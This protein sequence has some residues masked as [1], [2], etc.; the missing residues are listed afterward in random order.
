MYFRELSVQKINIAKT[1]P[2]GEKRGKESLPIILVIARQVLKINN[3]IFLEILV[4]HIIKKDKL[5]S[6]HTLLH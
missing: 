2:K 3:V 5:T 1:M 6:K 4:Y